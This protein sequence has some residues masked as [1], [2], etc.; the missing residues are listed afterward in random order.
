MIVRRTGNLTVTG[1]ALAAA[2]VGLA[3]CG[4]STGPGQPGEPAAKQAGST[5]E[6]RVKPSPDASAGSWTLTCQPPGGT[7]P[8]PE[9]ACAALRD[10]QDP[11]AAPSKQQICTQIYGGP[12][13]ASIE[14]EWSGKSVSADFSRKNGCEIKTWDALEPVFAPGKAAETGSGKGTEKGSPKSTG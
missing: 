3:A 2:V 5:L 4:G 14:G 12:Q 1:V 13:T 6:V 10:A 8:A 9:T 11:F 7:H